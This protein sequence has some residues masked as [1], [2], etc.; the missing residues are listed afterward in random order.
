MSDIKYV[1]KLTT[2]QTVGAIT[3]EPYG[4]HYEQDSGLDAVSNGVA[5]D[6]YVSGVLTNLS[7]YAMAVTP[8]VSAKKFYTPGTLASL[9]S[10]ATAGAGATAFVSDASTTLTLGIGTTVTGGGANA[11]PVYSDGANWIYG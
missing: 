9:G 6:K 4:A 3:V 7:P 5:F 1:N 10:A 11:V 2:S 8:E